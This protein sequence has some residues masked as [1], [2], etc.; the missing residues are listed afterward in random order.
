MSLTPISATFGIAVLASTGMLGWNA[1]DDQPA[2]PGSQRSV[3]V[4][5][6]SLD[7]AERLPLAGMAGQHVVVVPAA[8]PAALQVQAVLSPAVPAALPAQAPFPTQLQPRSQQTITANTPSGLQ[9]VALPAG[10]RWPSAMPNAMPG[11]MPSA[12]QATASPAPLRY[13]SAPVTSVQRMNM[14]MPVPMPAPASMPAQH[15]PGAQ[16][17]QSAPRHITPQP[18]SQQPANPQPGPAQPAMPQQATPAPA[19]PMPAAPAQTAIQVHGFDGIVA[20][21]RALLRRTASATLYEAHIAST[22]TIGEAEKIWADLSARLGQRLASANLHLKEIEV[23]NHGR[24]IRLLAGDFNDA[25]AT[26]D[27]CRAVIALGRDCRILRKFGQ[28]G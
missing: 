20:S 16:P 1:I 3:T 6:A 25:G 14:P 4:R 23:P 8:A 28:A 10:L 22:A 12:I 7:P 19:M 26:A 24:F 17:G 15:Q 18:A 13:A 2:A 21:E 5:V 11:A 27:F 9:P